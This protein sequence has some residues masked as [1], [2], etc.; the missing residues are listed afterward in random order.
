MYLMCLVL[1]CIL[2]PISSI[3]TSGFK[4]D[5]MSGPKMT[6]DPSLAVVYRKGQKIVMGYSDSDLEYKFWKIHAVTLWLLC[7]GLL[8]WCVIPNV[9]IVINWRED[10]WLV[11]TT[12][13]VDW[14]WPCGTDC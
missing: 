2:I 12:C 9:F 14:Y 10:G 11:N 6:D 7:R 4:L 5:D 1:A 8:V 13:Y 3:T